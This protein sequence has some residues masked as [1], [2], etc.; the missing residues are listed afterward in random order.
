MCSFRWKSNNLCLFTSMSH[1]LKLVKRQKKLCLNEI[2]MLAKFLKE[3]RKTSPSN[4]DVSKVFWTFLYFLDRT[5]T[6]ATQEFLKFLWTNSIVIN[7]ALGIFLKSK[8]NPMA[9]QNVLK[10]CKNLIHLKY[11]K[12]FAIS[13]FEIYG[14]FWILVPHLFYK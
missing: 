9:W 1:I 11:S 6:F 2:L 12:F 13:W 10:I 7:R 14:Y 4:L 3:R 8:S 5:K